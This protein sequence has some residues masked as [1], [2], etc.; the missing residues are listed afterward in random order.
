MEPFPLCNQ[1]ELFLPPF[2]LPLSLSL[3]IRPLT[4][5]LS[6]S[7]T[8]YPFLFKL[9]TQ[10]KQSQSLWVRAYCKKSLNFRQASSGVFW[11]ILNLDQLI[12]FAPL[13]D[14]KL[15]RIVFVLFRVLS[16]AVGDIFVVQI[17]SDILLG[18]LLHEPPSN[19]FSSNF[20][21]LG[22]LLS[23][24]RFLIKAA[25]GLFPVFPHA[26]SSLLIDFHLPLYSE[27]LL[28]LFSFLRQALQERHSVFHLECLPAS[29]SW[30]FPR[31]LPLLS[32]QYC[33]SK[34]IST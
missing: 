15:P 27:S 13:M 24:L 18:P 31:S 34:H 16:F 6:I 10:Q 2:W 5:P 7:L 17:F 3:S 22:K 8:S 30:V 21:Q 20:L 29:L 4:P 19:P 26:S 9:F 1:I 25:L 28:L 23:H 11:V 14:L 33:L 12:F 32:S